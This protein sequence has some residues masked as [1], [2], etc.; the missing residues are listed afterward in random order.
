[1]M[2]AAYE[3][4]QEG[5]I[6]PILVGDSARIKELVAERGYD[7]SVFTIVDIA[8]EEYKN[9][10]MGGQTDVT[11]YMEPL[12]IARIYSFRQDGTWSSIVDRDSYDRCTDAAYDAM[13]RVPSRQ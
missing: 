6:V 8:N 9:E 3:C 5:Y 10:A 2:Q 4:G 12:K 11:E 7:E 13:A 1:M